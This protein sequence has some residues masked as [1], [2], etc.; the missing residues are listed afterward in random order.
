MNLVEAVDYVVDFAGLHPELRF[1]INV[2]VKITDTLAVRDAVKRCHAAGIVLCMAA[3]N[4]GAPVSG[5]AA[6]SEVIAVGAVG[7]DGIRM[8]GK[9]C[10]GS[11]SSSNFGPELD[12]VAPGILLVTTDK[13][14]P[15]GFTSDDYNPGFT[16]TSGASP[17]VAGVVALLL[18]V[19]PDL[20]PDRIYEILKST[21][22][23]GTGASDEDT[24]GFDP[25]MGWGRIDAGRALALA[26]G[27]EPRR[28]D[29][30]CDGKAE[31]DDAIF[32]IGYLFQGKSAPTCPAAADVNG[33]GRLNIADPIYLVEWLFRSGPPPP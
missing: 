12:F 32:L 8:R 14:G 26:A 21:A 22:V 31:L 24:P 2:S 13:R 30:D 29:A 4:D 9:S 17:V 1:V 28:G 27:L 11:F 6:L 19:D 16:G 10:A 23:D 25:F 5:A 15:G 20:T 3:G 33:D 7:P 18:S